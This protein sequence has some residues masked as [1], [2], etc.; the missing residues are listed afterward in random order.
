MRDWAPLPAAIP[1]TLAAKS[2]VR[3]IPSAGLCIAVGKRPMRL[4]V[5]IS[6]ALKM[7][8]FLG[9]CPT[10]SSA[11]FISLLVLDG[12]CC[13]IPPGLLGQSSKKIRPQA[14]HPPPPNHPSEEV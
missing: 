3:V 1:E 10:L 7:R 12:H 13:Q 14:G 9:H 2:V 6:K 5:Y 4:P 8:W 11:S